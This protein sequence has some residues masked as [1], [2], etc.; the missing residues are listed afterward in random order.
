M[1]NVQADWDT[2]HFIANIQYNISKVVTFL[3]DFGQPRLSSHT[4]RS[5]VL[6]RSIDGL[7]AGPR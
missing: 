4:P 1:A 3:N 6:R 5:P 7:S 2:R